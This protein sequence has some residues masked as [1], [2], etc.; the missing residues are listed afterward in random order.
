MDP[1]FKPLQLGSLTLPNRIIMSPITRCRAGESR[2]P[3]SMMV[4]YYGQRATA[5]FILSEATSVTPMGVGYAGTPG[6]WCEDQVEGWKKVTKRV[7]AEGG[8]IFLQLWHVGRISHP[9]FLD[10]KKPVA[11]SAIKA[12]GHVS[13]VR[14]MTEY[15]TPRALETEEVKDIVDAFREGA[16]NA[17]KAGFD[18]VE[19]H[20]ANGY[21][22]DQFL[23][24]KTNRRDDLYGGALKTE[25]VFFSKSLMRSLKSGEPIEWE[26]TWLR[27]VTAMTWVIP[28]PFKLLA[29]SSA[30]SMNAELPLS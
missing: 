5:G 9:T 17:K 2:T 7:H 8:R 1:L 22:I 16:V 18:G 10:G 28:I 26:F 14:P 29:T 3:N 4:E 12:D 11:P 24:D 21:L 27:V 13:L 23:Q 30:N 25:P 19:I 20:A 6:I 15:P